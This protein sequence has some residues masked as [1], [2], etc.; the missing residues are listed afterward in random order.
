MGKDL[1][2]DSI[3]GINIKNRG[4]ATDQSLFALF[5]GP[6]WVRRVACRSRACVA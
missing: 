2:E 1:P 6:G 4:K 3:T 5:R